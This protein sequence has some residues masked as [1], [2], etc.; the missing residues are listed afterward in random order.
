MSNGKTPEPHQT[1]NHGDN[2]NPKQK[3]EAEIINLSP[4]DGLA[5]A[6]SIE[7]ER[8]LLGALLL[9]NRV[10]EDVGNFL[11]A[12]HFSD[13]FHRHIFEVCERLFEKGD[14]VTPVTLGV[15]LDSDDEEKSGDEIKEYLTNLAKEA[16][17]PT[18]PKLYA[19]LI[20]DLAI[21]RGL[22]AVVQQA[23]AGLGNKPDPSESATDLIEKLEQELYE[24]SQKGD[25]G[26]GPTAMNRV[27]AETLPNIERAH[28]ND[29]HISGA[30]SG[31]RD[32]DTILGGLHPSDLVILAARPSMGKTALAINVAWNVAN[33][34]L[35]QATAGQKPAGVVLFSL[36]MS[37]EQ[38]AT[39][40][41]SNITGVGSNFIRQG[42]ISKQDY[43]KIVTVSKAM[44]QLPI[45]IDD[46][47]SLSVGGLRS[48]ARR[49]KRRHNIGL[50]VVDYLQLLTAGAKI[51]NRVLEISQI[52]RTLKGIAKELGVPVLALSQL[53]RRTEERDDKTPQL[54][55]LRESGSIEQDADVVIF[56]Y[57][58]EYY[59]ERT[60]PHDEADEKF[61][62]WQARF[63]QVKNLAQLIVA[64]HRSGPTGKVQ[65]FFSAKNASFRDLAIPGGGE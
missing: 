54:A 45:Y 6:Y 19:N 59:L 56:I 8:G 26:G 23:A 25:I 11:K 33:L 22:L 58:E 60:R 39:R 42:L 18:P 44:Q 40:M 50:V 17:L 37:A 4:A 20:H 53:S 16:I 47:P 21:R 30:P 1:K 65:L 36:E 28:K 32:L 12:A 24:L 61:A 2:P 7:A 62:K 9:N 43:Q 49:L 51:E 52:T 34:A 27:M 57:R 10:W 13:P 38:V 41:I 63:E 35:A 48:R 3:V 15:Y 64:K 55:D 5:S 46:T 29:R 14:G 31:F